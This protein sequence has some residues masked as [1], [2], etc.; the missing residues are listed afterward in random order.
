MTTES[1]PFYVDESNLLNFS[2]PLLISK[3]LFPRFS[4][5]YQ[6]IIHNQS[7]F[8]QTVHG[9]IPFPKK[10]FSASEFSFANFSKFTSKPKK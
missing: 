4:A 10:V 9:E 5:G 1:K 7:Y 6:S 2:A 3:A 8:L